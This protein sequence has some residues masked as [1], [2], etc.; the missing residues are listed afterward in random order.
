VLSTM[1]DVPLTL[2]AV[3]RSGA[4]TF[5][6][7][8]VVTCTGPGGASRRATYGAVAE[9]AARLAGALRRLGVSGDDRVA[10]FA[11]NNQ[12]HLEAY[13]AVPC[14]GAVL[15]TLNIRLTPEQLGF[16]ATHAEDKV[17]LADVSLLPLLA[18]ALALMETVTT[19]LVVGD[20]D[21]EHHAAVAAT[22][23]TVLSYEEVL[24][25]ESPVF[26]WPEVDETSAAAMCY[27]S[28]TTGEPKGVVYSHRSAWLHSMG[29]CSGNVGAVTFRD[30]TLPVVPMFHANAWGLPYAALM[31]G[32]DL[33]MP[34]RF[35]QPE[36][37]VAFI[38]AERPTLA[39]AVPTVWNDMLQWL[40]RNPGHDVSSMTRVLCGGSA[41]PRVL[42]E[43]YRDELGVE[44][45]Q[46][47]GMTETSPVATSGL[48]PRGV[49]GE[50]E[51]DLRA[52]QGRFVFGVEGRLVDDEGAVLQH[53]G[54]AVGE[55]EVRGPWVTAGYYRGADAERFDT[56]DAG[57]VWLRTGDVGTIDPRGYLTLT[58]RAKDVIKSGGEWISSVELETTLAGHPDV[59][60]AA[61]VGVPDERWAERPLALVVRADGAAVTA[62]ELREWLSPQV[63]RWWLPE[64]WAFVDAV[65]RTGVGKFDK[66][67]V[68]RAY[69]D[70]E[71]T[72][73]TLEPA[74]RG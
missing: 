40:R 67:V 2:T 64:R 41:V 48:P 25:A 27:T 54:K 9:R 43:A 60:E 16:I 51:M 52:T 6:D 49:T 37:L 44:V 68:R 72:I 39:G 53:D 15:H 1:Q 24:A 5:S 31:A 46:A 10:T 45:R 71:L 62:A 21:P 14:S 13:L 56:D 11:W 58:D 47:W 55:V 26:A 12:E 63:A 20:A 73:E 22:G 23:K 34:D 33:V 8:E 65:P 38:E 28:G 18:P 30:R 50:E 74:A 19:V 29:V 17:L 69:A 35:L 3:L 70:G 36:P 4:T 32:A 61:V 66:K 42:I 57:A 7:G 59:V